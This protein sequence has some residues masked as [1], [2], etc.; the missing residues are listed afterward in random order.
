MLIIWLGSCSNVHA[1]CLRGAGKM[2][3][4]T[5]TKSPEGKHD[6]LSKNTPGNCQAGW[7]EVGAAR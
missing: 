5:Q 3:K 4:E 2:E 6:T 7:T 1:T